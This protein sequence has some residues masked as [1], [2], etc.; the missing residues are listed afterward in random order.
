MVGSEM[1]ELPLT[2]TQIKTERET[3][4]VRGVLRWKREREGEREKIRWKIQ[5]AEKRRGRG[6]KSRAREESDEP[7]RTAKAG[8]EEFNNSCLLCGWHP[9]VNKTF[10]LA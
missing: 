8:S 2:K 4:R 5:R 1:Q 9:R 10:P 6:G 7:R 3:W